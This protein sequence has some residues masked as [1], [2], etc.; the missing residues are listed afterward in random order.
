MSDRRKNE[1]SA[2]GRLRDKVCL[3]HDRLDRI[4]SSTVD[5][6]PDVNGCFSGNEF[7]IEVKTPTEP[8][9]RT[10]PLFGS[11]HKVSQSQKNW[12]L[13]Q[14]NADGIVF[15]YIRTDKR[16]LLIDGKFADDVNEMTV[17]ELIAISIYHNRLPF[18]NYND[19]AR[20][21]ACIIGHRNARP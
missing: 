17:E 3:Q 20:L 18:K 21:H 5:G 7:W 2:Y 14:W 16:I 10:T 13:R 15:L 19:W 11:N 9:R 6:I 8:K 12:M 1:K 4:E